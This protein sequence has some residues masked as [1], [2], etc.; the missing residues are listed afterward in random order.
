MM[1]AEDILDGVIRG[2]LGSRRKRHRGALDYL[3]GG[4]HSLLNAR[5]L[6]AAAGVAWGVYEASRSQPSATAPAAPIGAGPEALPPLPRVP[7]GPTEVAAPPGSDLIRLVRL[8]ISAARA[9]GDLSLDERGR[10]LEHARGVG[11]EAAVAAELQQPR[12]LAEIVAGVGDARL[13]TDMYRLAFAIVRADEAVSGA[14][15]VYLA[16]LAAKLGLDAATTGGIES[17]AAAAIDASA[18]KGR[19]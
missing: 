13:K 11:L 19:Q 2:A 7:S 5:T 10:I 16:Q 12:P 4:R 9:D 3:V 14:E 1:D 18:P 15:R 6:L 17:E 8:T